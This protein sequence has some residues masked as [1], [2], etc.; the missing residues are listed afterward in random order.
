MASFNLSISHV[1]LRA[2]KLYLAVD[3]IEADGYATA[4]RAPQDQSISF[5][6]IIHLEEG[7]SLSVRYTGVEGDEILGPDFTLDTD[8]PFYGRKLSTFFV[9]SIF[10]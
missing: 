4:W 3:N 10:T 7:E 2:R 1:G 9:S 6:G 8:H 5:S